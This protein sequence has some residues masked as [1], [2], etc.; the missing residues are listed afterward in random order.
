M[1]D[2]IQ[3]LRERANA[4]RNEGTATSLGDALHFEEAARALEAKIVEAPWQEPVAWMYRWKIDGVFVKWRLSDASQRSEHLQLKDYQEIALYSAPTTYADAEAKGRLSAR[5]EVAR[6]A[7]VLLRCNGA[8]LSEWG[9]DSLIDD[10][11][12][13]ALKA[14]ASPAP[15]GET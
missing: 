6:A 9:G 13:V 3:R 10:G 1:S 2:L 5:E 12:Q 7:S 11:A 4:A 15:K 14:L 8:D